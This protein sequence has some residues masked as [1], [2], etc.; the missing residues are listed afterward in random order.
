MEKIRIDKYLWAI[1]IYKSRTMATEACREGK[2]KLNGVVVKSSALTV[3]GDTI[4]VHKDSFRFKY[5]VVQLIEKRV[6]AI[7]AKPCYEDLTPEE[8]LNKYKM[9]FVGKGGPERRERGAGRPTKKERREIEGYK[10]GD[11]EED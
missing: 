2:V 8:E 11:D 10:E 4:E 9:W 6:S 1:R 7:L 5:K 3:I